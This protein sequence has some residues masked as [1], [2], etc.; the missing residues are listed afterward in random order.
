[1]AFHLVRHAHTTEQN[2]YKSDGFSTEKADMVGTWF[3][4]YNSDLP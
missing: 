4:D 1:V 2:R 3:A